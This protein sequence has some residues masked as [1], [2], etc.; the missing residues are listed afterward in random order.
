LKEES[1]TVQGGT[2]QSSSMLGMLS[3]GMGSYLFKKK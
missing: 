2:T 1:T 3:T